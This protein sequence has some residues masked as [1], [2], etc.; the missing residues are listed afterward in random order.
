MSRGAARTCRCRSARSCSTPRTSPSASTT[1]AV[2]AATRT[3]GSTRCGR[4]GSTSGATS[5]TTRAGS[6]ACATTGGRR[7]GRGARPPSPSRARARTVPGC[8]RPPGRTVTQMH[9]ARR[10]EVTPEMEFVALREGMDPTFVR[11]EVARGPGHHPGQRQPP[12]ER[13]DDHRHPLPHEDQRQHRHLGGHVVGGRRGEQAHV[14]HAVGRRHG[15]GPVDRARHPHHPRVDRPQQPRAHRHRPDLPGAREGRRRARGPDLGAVPRHRHRAGRAGRRLHDHPR[16]RAAAL[17]ADDRRAGHGHRQPRRVDPRRLVPG[18][19]PG[20][21]PLRALRRAVRDLRRLRRGL[22]PGRR[23]APGLDRRRQR[24]GPAG[25]AGH[26]RRADPGGVAARRPGHDRGPRA[27]A[28]CTRSRRTSSCRWSCARRRPSTRS[29][30]SPPTSL[31]ATTT[32]R[33]PSARR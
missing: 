7:S 27:R 32:S 21:L 10:G 31:P 24:R 1:P 17:R 30:R 6:P 29:A 9:Y 18:P 16:R 20:E 5:S 19:P 26:P 14:G 4:R 15:H 13:A 3:P 8:G 33:R 23:A 22:Q 2:R 11:D 12:R 28:R 25:R